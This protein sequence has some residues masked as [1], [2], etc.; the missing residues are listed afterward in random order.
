FIPLDIPTFLTSPWVSAWED[1][2][3]RDNFWNYTLRS[4]ISGEF[5]FSGQA[6]TW[7]A[8]V[9]GVIL[10]MLVLTG[11]LYL[12]FRV[13][14]ALTGSFWKVFYSPYFPMF[15]LGFFWMASLLVLRYKYPYSCSNDFR[16]V[17][18]VILPFVICC[19]RVATGRFWLWAF[20]IGSGLFFVLL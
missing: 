11:M 14:E 1:K 18:P 20:G 10:L 4:S 7:L 2:T 12:A 5:Q 6:Q 15:L 19:A 17:L 8:Y 13:K 3:G 16:Y 9:I